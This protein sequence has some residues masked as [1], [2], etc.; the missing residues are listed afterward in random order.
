MGNIPGKILGNIL[1]KVL[2]NFPWNEIFFVL[3][4]GIFF[5]AIYDFALGPFVKFEEKFPW[6]LY[7]AAAATHCNFT[8]PPWLG[9]I[10]K[11]KRSFKAIYWIQTDWDGHY[12]ADFTAEGMQRRSLVSTTSKRTTGW[13]NVK[14]NADRSITPGSSQNC[15]QHHNMEICHKRT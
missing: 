9:L 10:V 7:N 1:G 12:T 2:E 3:F 15:S 13:F 5:I 11:R 4:R 8:L 6:F 14:K